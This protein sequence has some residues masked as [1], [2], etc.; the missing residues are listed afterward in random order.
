MDKIHGLEF[1]LGWQ[2]DR[3]AYVLPFNIVWTWLS[4]AIIWLGVVAWAGFKRDWATAMSFGQLLAASLTL[5][6]LYARD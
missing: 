1:I 5:L 2:L 3:I 6:F 4:L